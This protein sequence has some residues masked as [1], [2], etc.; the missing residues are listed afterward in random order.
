MDW[1]LVLPWFVVVC[2]FP[3][4]LFFCPPAFHS[5]KD[6]CHFSLSPFVPSSH[7]WKR[8]LYLRQRAGTRLELS[9]AAQTQVWPI[10]HSSIPS[11]G[12]GRFPRQYLLIAASSARRRDTCCERTPAVQFRS[13]LVSTRHGASRGR[14]CLSRVSWLVCTVYTYI[15]VG[16]GFASVNTE[17]I[18][19]DWARQ[20]GRSQEL[21]NVSWCT[22][23]TQTWCVLFFL[24]SLSNSC[25]NT[26]VRHAFY[27]FEW[28]MII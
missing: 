16:L 13:Q 10:W 4:F 25:C 5:Q 19:E 3:F 21:L 27:T 8:F 24:F 18:R 28:T 22:A 2:C 12:R 1:T 9:R 15:L 26:T 23:Q 14:A 6:I 7:I 11:T 20:K 17:C